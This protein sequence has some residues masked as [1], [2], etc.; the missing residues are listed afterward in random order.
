ML[1]DMG[2]RRLCESLCESLCGKVRMPSIQG[3]SVVKEP[4][5]QPAAGTGKGLW[6]LW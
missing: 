3:E 5:G 4:I 2:V 6:G 1:V